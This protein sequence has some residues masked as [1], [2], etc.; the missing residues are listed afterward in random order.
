MKMGNMFRYSVC[1]AFV[2]V[3]FA[4][5]E[6][7]SDIIYGVN[8]VEVTRPTGAKGSQ[9]SLTEF[10]SIAYADIFEANISQD[11]LI[12]LSTPYAG[13]GDLKYIEDLIIRNF[14]NNPNAQVPTSQSMRNDVNR[15][16]TETYQRFYNRNPN[17][18]ELWFMKNLVDDNADIT[19]ELVYYSMMT[20]NE[21]RYY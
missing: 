4:S 19:P 13:F 21:Y 17:E 10:I 5:C 14:L 3:F 7:E 18:Y 20:S 15:F 1:I 16:V 9:K 2:V 12:G 11:Q 6:K 8:D